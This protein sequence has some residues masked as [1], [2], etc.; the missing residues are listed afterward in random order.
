M[1]PSFI[2]EQTLR[3]TSGLGLQLSKGSRGEGSPESLGR[4]GAESLVLSCCWGLRGR[5]GVLGL[6]FM[7]TVQRKCGQGTSMLRP[8][9]RMCCLRQGR[10]LFGEGYLGLGLDVA[11]TGLRVYGLVGVVGSCADT[12]RRVLANVCDLRLL[13]CCTGSGLL[14]SRRL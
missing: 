14:S 8:S 13:L 10:T 7:G 9:I 4:S 6:G 3:N 11:F 1:H 12:F 5:F 2:T